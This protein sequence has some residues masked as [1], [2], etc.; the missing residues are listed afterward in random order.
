MSESVRD[1]Y[2]LV[3]PFRGTVIDS[4]G[5]RVQLLVDRDTLEYPAPGA[6]VEV[7]QGAEGCQA[8]WEYGGGTVFSCERGFSHEDDHKCFLLSDSWQG[9]VHWKARE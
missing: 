8:V 5:G 2:P 7:V 1:S 9:F 4:G 3:K 6:R